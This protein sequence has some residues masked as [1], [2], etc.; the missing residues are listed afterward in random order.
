MIHP[1]FHKAKEYSQEKHF[2]GIFLTKL[3]K[4]TARIN[5][6]CVFATCFLLFLFQEKS[7]LLVPGITFFDV[8]MIH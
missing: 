1:S 7:K 8:I 4:K 3:E 5:Y 6:M 2:C